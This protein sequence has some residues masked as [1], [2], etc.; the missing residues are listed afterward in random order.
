[1]TNLFSVHAGFSVKLG[2]DASFA[3]LPG[4]SK[5]NIAL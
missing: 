5:V 3:D 2:E 4:R 1:L